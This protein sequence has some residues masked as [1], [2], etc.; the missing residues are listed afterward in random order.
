MGVKF[1]KYDKNINKLEESYP[2]EYNNAISSGRYKQFKN[3]I[4]EFLESKDL[5]FSFLAESTLK[6]F[7][8]K[9]KKFKKIRVKIGL[10]RTLGSASTFTSR[11][12]SKNKVITEIE[13]GIKGNAPIVKELLTLYYRLLAIDSLYKTN[14]SDKAQKLFQNSFKKIFPDLKSLETLV[15]KNSDIFSKPNAKK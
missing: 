14:Y 3:N 8:K 15:E 11:E 1:A 5:I 6:N 9:L 7:E 12:K 2:S 13:K 4:E 10:C